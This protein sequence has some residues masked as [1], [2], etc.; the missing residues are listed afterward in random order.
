MSKEKV[1]SL[2]DEAKNAFDKYARFMPENVTYLVNDMFR[3]WNDDVGSRAIASLQSISGEWRNAIEEGLY[4]T[5]D[6]LL[7][8]KN[9]YK[10]IEAAKQ[11]AANAISV[12]ESAAK[13]VK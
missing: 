13:R 1:S 4:G 11:D 5:M 8:V 3:D 7:A 9:A 2:N 10:E 12:A 6:A